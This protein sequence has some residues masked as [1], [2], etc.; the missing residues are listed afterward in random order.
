MIEEVW[1]SCYQVIP[2]KDLVTNL[3]SHL[4]QYSVAE[5]EDDIHSGILNKTIRIAARTQ[6]LLPILILIGLI[7]MRFYIHRPK[8]K[9][10]AFRIF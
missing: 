8:L 5:I 2:D 4:A 10:Q 1:L 9:S 7:F 3:L 6:V